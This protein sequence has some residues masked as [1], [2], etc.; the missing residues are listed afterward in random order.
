MGVEN[1]AYVWH[2]ISDKIG[3][4]TWQYWP[5][6]EYV[7]W[8]GLSFYAGRQVEHAEA[9]ARFARQH[10]K[11]QIVMEKVPW[12][13]RRGRLE[14]WHEPFLRNCRALG[15]KAICYNNWREP[16]VDRMFHNSAFDRMPRPIARAWGRA[17]KSP[18]YLHASPDLYEI[19]EGRRRPS[20]RNRRSPRP[21][22]R[23]VATP[24]TSSRQSTRAGCRRGRPGGS[25]ARCSPSR[26]TRNGLAS[27]SLM[28]RPRSMT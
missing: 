25:P 24:S 4:P 20:L 7:D 26:G 3:P 23:P 16:P 6:D 9:L 1:V 21:S 12:E 8:I 15:V 18:A 10:R 5:G 11:P 28:T 17:M 2:S 27:R 13:A 14:D 19:L 22:H